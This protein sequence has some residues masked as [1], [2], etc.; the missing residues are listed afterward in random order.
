MYHPA[1]AL[2]QGSLRRVIEEDFKKL[3]AYVE[4]ALR[5]YEEARQPVLAA[6]PAAP[7]VEQGRLF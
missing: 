3:P 2:H 5:E 6:P 1:A 4:Q 7:A